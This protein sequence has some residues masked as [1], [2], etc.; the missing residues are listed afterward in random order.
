MPPISYKLCFEACRTQI[1]KNIFFLLRV[2]EVERGAGGQRRFGQIPKFDRFLVL[3]PPL[4]F[5]CLTMRNC[6]N[7]FY[8]HLVTLWGRNVGIVRLLEGTGSV[9]D[10]PQTVRYVVYMF[11]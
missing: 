1:S 11:P 6:L 5:F 4:I 3:K 8:Y 10:F 2:S 7:C 9:L